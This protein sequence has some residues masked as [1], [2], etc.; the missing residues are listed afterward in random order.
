MADKYERFVA[1]F[2]R[3]NAYFTVPNFI[4]HAGDDPTRISSGQVGNYTE[5]DILALRMPYSQEVTGTLKI[6][7]YPG[8][9]SGAGDRMDI[10]LA[11]VK[12]RKNNKPNGVWLTGTPDPSIIYMVRFIG[13][14]DDAQVPRVAQALATA[15]RFEDARSRYRYIVFSAEPNEHY[16]SK[17]VEY[18]TFRQ[19]IDFIVTIRGQ[20]WIEANI[21]VASCH[22]QWDDLLKDILGIAND[23]SRTIEDRADEIEAFLAT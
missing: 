4:I 22:H 2:L 17:G 14:H 21:G 18:I 7:N 10:V 23:H 6:A 19:A 3:L 9:V 12:S 20:C 13:C 8:L 15:Y 11:E 1:A 16:L 5:T